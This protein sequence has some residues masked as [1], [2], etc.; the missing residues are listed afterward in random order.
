MG[1]GLAWGF[2]LGQSQRSLTSPTSSDREVVPFC[3]K[4]SSTHHPPSGSLAP[5]APLGIFHLPKK[6]LMI[7]SPC[8]A[9]INLR[10]QWLG[11]DWGLWPYADEDYSSISCGSEGTPQTFLPAIKATWLSSI[12]LG[13]KKKR[14]PLRKEINYVLYAWHEIKMGRLRWRTVDLLCNLQWLLRPQ[15]ASCGCSL[16]RQWPSA[17]GWTSQWKRAQGFH[18]HGVEPT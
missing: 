3:C 11:G 4:P 10:G 12:A 8:E 18:L 13:K 17:L 7:V 6:V 5:P 16:G 1:W 2:C 9:L 14:S 15:R